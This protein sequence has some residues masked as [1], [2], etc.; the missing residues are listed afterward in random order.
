MGDFEILLSS[1]DELGNDLLDPRR[2]GLGIGRDDD[3][4]V[5][6]DEIVPNGRV[7]MVIVKLT[8]LLR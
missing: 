5:A 6:E 7:K 2:S 1:E 8:G 3:V 4:V